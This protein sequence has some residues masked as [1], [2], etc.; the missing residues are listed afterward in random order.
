[1]C[2]RDSSVIDIDATLRGV[3]IRSRDSEVVE[4]V[5]I[6]VGDCELEAVERVRQ[7]G[8]VFEDAPWR[9]P[10][11]DAI[12]AAVIQVDATDGIEAADVLLGRADRQIRVAVT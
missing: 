2:I 12:G 11:A 1:M 4:S 10:I 9:A 7:A 3:V 8:G 5:A 6:E